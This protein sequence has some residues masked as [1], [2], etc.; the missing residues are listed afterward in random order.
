LRR[1][2]KLTRKIPCSLQNWSKGE[3]RALTSTIY[4]K[5]CY[6]TDSTPISLIGL[7]GNYRY[8]H[9]IVVLEEAFEF[10]P[11][12]YSSLREAIRGVNKIT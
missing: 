3:I 12:T 4:C 5:G 1:D 8:S 2:I 10:D 6:M 7:A 9:C 11:K